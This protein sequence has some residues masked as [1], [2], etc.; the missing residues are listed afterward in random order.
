MGKNPTP[1]Y[2]QKIKIFYSF[3]MSWYGF[4]INTDVKEKKQ[5]GGGGGVRS[6]PLYRQK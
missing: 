2:D 4:W 3:Q 6:S 5:G 1:P